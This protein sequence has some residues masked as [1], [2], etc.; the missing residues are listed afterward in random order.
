MRSSA[1]LE[2][3]LEL[4]LGEE[5][6]VQED[7]VLMSLIVA[8]RSS[9]VLERTLDEGNHVLRL[10]G[11][12]DLRLLGVSVLCLSSVCELRLLSVGGMRLL[13]VSELRL[14]D[15]NVSRS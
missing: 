6:L 12:S 13:G 3:V 8:V 9:A 15:V 11:V 2:V 14:L 7:R 4:T 5:E 1:V 10:L